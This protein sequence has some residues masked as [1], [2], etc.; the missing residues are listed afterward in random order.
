[1]ICQLVFVSFTARERELIN[2]K[3][4]RN[5]IVRVFLEDVFGCASTKR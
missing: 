4:K 3:G 2:K 5:D 1:M